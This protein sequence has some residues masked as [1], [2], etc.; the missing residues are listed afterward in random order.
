MWFGSSLTASG[1]GVPAPGTRTVPSAATP[2]SGNRP[3]NADRARPISCMTPESVPPSI[4]TASRRSAT[5]TTSSRST[6]ATV[7]NSFSP[8][9]PAPP[10]S[11]MTARSR[12]SPALSSAAAISSVL[13][14]RMR[15]AWMSP[16]WSFIGAPRC[17]DDPT[18]GP[19]ISRPRIHEA[20][21]RAAMRE[22]RP[23]TT[24]AAHGSGRLVLDAAAR[25]LAGVRAEE[26]EIE[27]SLAQEMASAAVS[28]GGTGRATIGPRTAGPSGPGGGEGQRPSDTLH[29]R[30]QD[31]P[32]TVFA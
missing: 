21:Y 3:P 32:R 19:P 8:M 23:V 4:T 13:A 24:G 30:V 20:E 14:I 11:T 9:M 7:S 2:M 1:D 28:Q 5:G 29:P 17:R 15:A 12:R 18:T 26:R 6:W 22:V 10:T 27:K 31:R 25:K 16:A